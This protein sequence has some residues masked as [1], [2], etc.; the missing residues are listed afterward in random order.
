MLYHFGIAN[1]PEVHNKRVVPTI[2]FPNTE[3]VGQ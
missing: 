2:A 3:I 1:N